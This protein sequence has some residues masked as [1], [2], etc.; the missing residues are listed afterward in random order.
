M[1]KAVFISL[2]ICA[3][4]PLLWFGLMF[5][6]SV[7]DP[8]SAKEITVHL[9]AASVEPNTTADTVAK[10][11]DSE[12]VRNGFSRDQQT[13][14]PGG[15]NWVKVYSYSSRNYPPN[16]DAMSSGCRVREARD[17]VRIELWELGVLRPTKQF[18]K[19]RHEL[20]DALVKK[21]GK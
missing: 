17:Q 6:V 7:A 20:K 1:R 11:V 13:H 3:A 15:T 9:A 2:G 10:F 21:C 19:V 16:T 4:I 8:A 5:A 14:D 18:A 12:L